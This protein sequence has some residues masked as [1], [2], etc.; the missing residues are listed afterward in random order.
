MSTGDRVHHTRNDTSTVMAS[1]HPRGA[2]F[3]VL[4]RIARHRTTEDTFVPRHRLD[5]EPDFVKSA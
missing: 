5:V 2:G 1:A 4:S 3:R